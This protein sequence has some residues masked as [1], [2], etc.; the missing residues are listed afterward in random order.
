MPQ[1]FITDTFKISMDLVHLLYNIT[2]YLFQ[3]YSLINLV[4]QLNIPENVV[5]ILFIVVI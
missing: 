5:V 2:M 1:I 4:K 3:F